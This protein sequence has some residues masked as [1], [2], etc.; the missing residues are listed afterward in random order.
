[1]SAQAAVTAAQATLAAAQ[2]NVTQRQAALAAAQA[3]LAQARTTSQRLAAQRVIA[4]AQ[5]A[6]A[7]AQTAV[8]AATANLAAKQAILAAVATPALAPAPAPTPV[9]P[10][11]KRALL[12]GINYTGTSY[13]LYGCINDAKNM[14][15]QLQT[16]YPMCREYRLITDETTEKPTRANIL[17]AI[18][19]LTAGLRPGENVMFHYSG[20]GGRVRDTNGDEVTGLDSCIYP[21]NSGRMETI[22]DDELRSRLAMRIPAGAKCL[23]VLD[24]CHSGT[25]VDLRCQWQAIAA[26]KLTFTENARYAKTA[27]SVLFLSGCRDSQSSMDT[28]G[29]DDRPCGA[30]TMALLETWKTY[31]AAIKL[32]YLLWDV[33]K[34]L[35]DYGYEQVPELT[36][37]AFM[38]M[39]GVFDLGA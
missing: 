13:E 25:A 3:A 24:S 7:A 35:V 36:T 23:V 21:V 39:N 17:A 18:D 20:H 4:A 15:T 38:D 22:I 27:G 10:G 14:Q 32:K 6:L 26:D 31:G 34:F 33:R 37:G 11:L 19:W 12:V 1:M 8:T 5:S 9:T 28:V 30:M 29:K 16:Y 2:R